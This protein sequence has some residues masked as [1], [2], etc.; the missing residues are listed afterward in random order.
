MTRPSQAEL[1]KA[2]VKAV[3]RWC[4]AQQPRGSINAYRLE[5][6]AAELNKRAIVVRFLDGKAIA[7]LVTP[8]HPRAS[9]ED[10]ETALRT[11]TRPRRTR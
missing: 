5:E 6:L 4:R 2:A 7:E 1:R 9:V 11:F 3:L 10:I 8:R